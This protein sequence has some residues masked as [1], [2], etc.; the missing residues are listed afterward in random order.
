M[1]SYEHE[2]R[3]MDETLGGAIANLMD[4]LRELF[5][6]IRKTFTR[7]EADHG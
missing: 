3:I 7:R 1:L 4:A 2:K 6:E 5:A